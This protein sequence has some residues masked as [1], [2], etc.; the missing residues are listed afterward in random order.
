MKR[1]AII[2][3]AFL[4]ACAA[5]AKE[6]PD[7]GVRAEAALKQAFEGAD[8]K[9]VARVLEQDD[10]QRLCTRYRDAPPPEVAQSILEMSRASIRYPE[11]GVL[12]GDWKRGK[13]IA[14]ELSGM[15]F[16]DLATKPNGGNCYA[17]HQI[18]ARETAFGTVGPSL[19]AYGVLRGSSEA[20]QR[21]TYARIYNAQAFTACATMPRFGHNG[22]LTPEQIVNLVA[23]LLDPASPVNQ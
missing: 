14:E 11:S 2:V 17:C 15:R 3:A 13:A 4:G 10:V 9:I 23:Y 18:E 19:R 8:P 5:P 6:Q 1:L 12:M 22:V 21:L 16:G 7:D 20:M